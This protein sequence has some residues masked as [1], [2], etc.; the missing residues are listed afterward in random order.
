MRFLRQGRVPPDLDSRR[1]MK[2]IAA[3]LP[4]CATTSLK[5]AFESEWLDCYPAMHMAG[6]VPWPEKSQLVIDA[7]YEENTQKRRKILHSLFDGYAA[8][9]GENLCA[10]REL[11]ASE[12]GRQHRFNASNIRIDFPGV[13]FIDDL[14]DMYPNAKIILNQRSD[15]SLWAKSLDDT[16]MF[17][18]SWTYR[19]TTFLSKMNRLHARMHLAAFDLSKRKIGIGRTRDLETYK[20]WY[21]EYN[22]FVRD[23]ARWRGRPVLEWEPRDGW[24]PICEFLGRPAPPETVAFPHAN[25][26]WEMQQL[27]IFLVSLGLLYWALLGVGV[28]AVTLVILWGRRI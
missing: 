23:E 11:F 20:I 24:A 10:G 15:A 7:L 2:V 4:R 25:D 22:R 8:I 17:F 12:L 21:K 14:M 9:C 3:G 6:V 5:E 16:L 19:I 13:A 1:E 18:S 27:K 26:R 28:W